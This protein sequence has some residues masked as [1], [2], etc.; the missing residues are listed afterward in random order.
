MRAQHRWERLKM[1]DAGSGHGRRTCKRCRLI[2][3]LVQPLRSRSVMALYGRDNL[4][5]AS[6]RTP[7]VTPEMARWIDTHSLADAGR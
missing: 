2:Q 7:C 4:T 5:W 3:L 1:G 6:G